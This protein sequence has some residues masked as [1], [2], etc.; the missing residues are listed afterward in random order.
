MSVPPEVAFFTPFL[1]PLH[2]GLGQRA[3]SLEKLVAQ[4]F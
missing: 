4:L 3:F 2:K 1:L